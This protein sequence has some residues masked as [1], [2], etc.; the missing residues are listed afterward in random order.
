MK[1]ER[2]FRRQVSVSHHTAYEITFAFQNVQ[3]IATFSDYLE[4]RCVI[5]ADNFMTD[6]E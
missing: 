1:T 2:W 4:S 6:P 3:Y 5:Q